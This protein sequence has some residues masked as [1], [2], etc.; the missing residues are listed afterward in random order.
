MFVV[1][2][3]NISFKLFIEMQVILIP[4]YGLLLTLQL[5]KFNDFE[6]KVNY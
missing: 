3:T 2:K 6:V 5:S 1:V 4:S